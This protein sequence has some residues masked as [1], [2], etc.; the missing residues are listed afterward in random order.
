M[1]CVNER[2]RRFA[3]VV[4]GGVEVQDR[5]G[6]RLVLPCA[7]PPADPAEQARW[8]RNVDAAFLDVVLTDVLAKVA[9]LPA[10]PA[11]GG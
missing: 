11:A 8:A 5:G 9:Q 10:M 7:P 6:R 4:E 2:S 1:I 3:R